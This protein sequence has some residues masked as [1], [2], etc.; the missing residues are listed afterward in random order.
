MTTTATKT[1]LVAIYAALLA[2]VFVSTSFGGSAS[3]QQLIEYGSDRHGSDIPGADVQLEED[4]GPLACVSA[5][6]GNTDCRAW[7]FLRSG[8]FQGDTH[9]YCKLKYAAPRKTDDP[10]TASGV[11]A[12][13]YSR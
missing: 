1:T 7:A 2:G 9:A 6:N 11:K 13:Y 8:Y 10:R 5:C 4:D 3:A 12:S